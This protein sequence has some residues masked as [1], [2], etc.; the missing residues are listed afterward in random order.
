MRFT[1]LQRKLTRD[2]KT[3][4]AFADF[5][6]RVALEALKGGETAAKLASHYGVHLTLIHRW[7]RALLADASSVLERGGRK[8]PEIDEEQ[9]NELYAKIG[10]LAV[11]RSFLE[12][13][14]KLWA[15][16]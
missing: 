1:F 6:A 13:K 14:L 15:G 10:K 2:A 7:K 11:T 4:A 3:Q 5:K 8:Q 16:K 12:R 9:V